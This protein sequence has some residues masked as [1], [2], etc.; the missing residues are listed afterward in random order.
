MRS[1]W[2]LS[3]L[4]ISIL[5][6]TGCTEKTEELVNQGTEVID[7]VVGTGTEVMD[8]VQKVDA[9]VTNVVSSFS[10]KVQ[11]VQELEY[12][13]NEEKF[14]LEELFDAVLEDPK[15]EA[16]EIEGVDVVKVTGGIK[17][18]ILSKEADGY[19][20]EE[21]ISD[22]LNETARISFVFPFYEG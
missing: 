10:V 1:G 11:L 19:K 4:G 22:V 9:E 20:H 8:N 17:E 3:L 15:W 12:D 7:N 16:G 6:L 5:L 21:I 14:N 13:Y 18:D 2:K